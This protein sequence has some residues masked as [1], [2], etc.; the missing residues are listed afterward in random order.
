MVD[1]YWDKADRNAVAA[2][3][4][5][6][7]YTNV[8][9]GQTPGTQ[10]FVPQGGGGIYGRK[11]TPVARAAPSPVATYATRQASL[12]K[13]ANTANDA[14][15]DE[16]RRLLGLEDP[17]EWQKL[18]FGSREAYEAHKARLANEA[19]ATA[20]M[21]STGPMINP[22]GVG[23]Q[24]GNITPQAL[25]S[26]V[27]S[28]QRGIYNTSTALNKEA[29]TN[30]L[31]MQDAARANQGQALQSA[32][33]ADQIRRGQAAEDA[34]LRNQRLQWIYNRTDQGPNLDRLQQVAAA[35]GQGNTEG[36]GYPMAQGGGGGGGG[37]QQQQQ[38]DQQQQYL[39]PE[40][41]DALKKQQAAYQKKLDTAAGNR[42]NAYA[43]LRAL[44]R[45]PVVA[46]T[47]PLTPAYGSNLWQRATQGIIPRPAVG[48]PVPLRRGP[49]AD[50][51]YSP[52]PS[53]NP[54]FRG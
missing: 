5:Y 2:P 23:A 12:L 53:A 54:F 19:V 25:A 50:Y 15:Y 9:S 34:D 16:G 7:G 33:V 11:P 30:S 21:V 8:F 10:R 1:T 48:P 27:Q 45:K 43:T 51:V 52:R 17:N 24:G 46:P 31:A 13:D 32:Q 6:Q 44:K 26:R 40:E 22:A 20:P 42:A 29:V 3:A 35:E 36:M 28:M 37:D 47:A 14:R 4:G 18:G 38:Q 39:S 49:I 41:Q